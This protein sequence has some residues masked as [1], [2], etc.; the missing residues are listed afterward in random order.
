MIKFLHIIY[1][2]LA[3]SKNESLFNHENNQEGLEES[4]EDELSEDDSV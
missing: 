4:S 2:D 1:N 3:K